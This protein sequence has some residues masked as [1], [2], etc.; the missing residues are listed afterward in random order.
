MKIITTK[1]IL[2]LIP[3]A[4][5]FAVIFMPAPKEDEIL[6]EPVVGITDNKRIT[7]T[8]KGE[9]LNK[10][11]YVLYEGKTIR[12]LLNKCG[13]TDYTDVSSIN[14]DEKLKN[15]YTYNISVIDEAKKELGIT[16]ISG[17][18][19]EKININTATKEELMELEKIGSER[20]QAIIEYR[21]VRKFSTIDDIKNVTGISEAIF[22]A[23]KNYITV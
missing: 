11:T 22:D 5:I 19:E 6:A 12:D 15:G 8:V 3:I 23:I 4:L 21:S 18:V 16:I 13:L 7:V 10:G 2:A 1:Y 20:A 14:L 17:S 9:V